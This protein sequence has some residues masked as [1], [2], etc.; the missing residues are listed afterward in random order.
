[1]Y[2][3]VLVVASQNRSAMG[4]WPGQK[5]QA[6]E[7][8]LRAAI[9]PGYWLDILPALGTTGGSTAQV[10]VESFSPQHKSQGPLLVPFLE[11]TSI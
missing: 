2:G 5:E 6:A 1:M 10:S 7:E 9:P 4:S 11:V 8:W 3:L